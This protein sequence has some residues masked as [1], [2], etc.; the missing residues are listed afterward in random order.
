MKHWFITGISRG[1][2]L[3][4]AKAAIANGDRVWGT[5]RGAAP[6]IAHVP[7]Q[8]NAVRLDLGDVPQVVPTVQRVFED[9]GRVDV[10]VNN[11]GFGLLGAVE[12]VTDEALYQLFEVD[13]FGPIR[14]VRAAMPFLRTQGH[15]HVV[16]ITSI[17]GRAPGVGSALYAT[18]KFALE[19]FSAALAQEVGA[20]GVH[21]TAVAPGQFRT[22][23]LSDTSLKR[24]TGTGAASS[25]ALD[26]A[27]AQLAS[28]NQHQ[29]GDPDRAAQAILQVVYSAAPPRQLLLGSDAL[30]RATR[31][32]QAMTD[33]MLAW[34]ALTRSTDFPVEP[35]AR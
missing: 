12:N 4:M 23:F 26:A 6:D 5:T 34:E 22:D 35:T 8:L 3:A 2:G 29:P 16:N 17:A 20:F 31:Q 33:E 13:V 10:I 24:S 9:M 18:A 19:G 27:L 15:G 14:I 30:A 21:V 7:G 11:A 32:Q 25:S 28:I 1:L